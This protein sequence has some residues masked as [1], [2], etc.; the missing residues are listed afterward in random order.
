MGLFNKGGKGI[1][2]GSFDFNGD[3]KTNNLEKFISYKIF[4]EFTNEDNDTSYDSDISKKH[5]WRDTCDD[6]SDEDIDPED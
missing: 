3:G 6:G 2:N 1:F 5:A 4:E